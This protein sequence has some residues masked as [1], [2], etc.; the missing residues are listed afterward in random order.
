MVGQQLS[1]YTI[2]AKIGEG[3]MGAVY[4]AVDTR[5]NRVVAIKVL[6]AEA[7]ADESRKRRFVQE[8]QAASALN[9]PNIVTIYD[10]DSVGG[11]DFIAMEHVEGESLDRMIAAAPLAVDRALDYAVQIAAALSAAH[12]AG[13]IHRDLK[14]ANV[15]VS[16]AGT[17]KV[18]DFGL[19]KLAYA[20]SADLLG[21]TRTA[22]PPTASGLILGTAGYMAPEQAEG[23]AVDAR[24]DIFSF[25]AVLYEMLAGRRA[26]EGRSALS[27]IA[28]VLHEQPAPLRGLRAQVPPELERIVSRCLEKDPQNRYASAAAL[29]EDLRACQ[30]TLT[31]FTTAPPRRFTPVMAVVLV[32]VLAAAAAAVGW[33]WVRNARVRNARNVTLPQIEAMIRNGQYDPAFRLL[34]QLERIIPDDPQLARLRTDATSPAS[35]HTVPPGAEA[36]TKAYLDPAGEWLPLGRTPRENVRVPFGY[37]RWRFTKEGYEPREGA[38]SPLRVPVVTLSRTGDAPAGMVHVPGTYAGAPGAPVPLQDF[39]LDR[40]EVTNRQFKAFVDRGAYANRAYWKHP[41]VKDGRTLSWDEAMMEFRDATGRPGPS[42]WELGAYP[43][44]RADQPVT[45]VSWYEAAAYADHAG[46]SLPSFFHWRHAATFGIFSDILVLSNFSGKGLA[47]V[48]EYQGLATFGTFD[49]AGNAK[50]WCFNSIGAK[51]YILGGAW[52]EPSYMFRDRDAQLPFGREATYGF[53]CAK[54]LQPLAEQLVSPVE[55]TVRD[56]S[57]ERPASDEAFRLYQSL[58]TYDRTPLN[59]AVEALPD[60]SP[61]W[62]KEK[63]T[64]DAA[65]GGERVPAFL[66]LP[67]RAAPPFQTVVYFPP[68]SALYLRS[69]AHLETRQM[70]FLILSGRAVLF[71]IYRGTYDRGVPITGAR[72]WRDLVI[73]WSKDLGRSIDYLETRKDIVSSR[74]AFF[75]ISMGSSPTLL[76]HE[77][78]LKAAVLLGAGFPPSKDLPEIDAINFAPRT[79]VPVL[80]LNGRLDFELPV[81]TSQRPMFQFLGAPPQHK[82]HVIFE[83]GHAVVAI[84]PM[85]REVLDW[86][87]RYLGPVRTSAP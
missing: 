46:K 87:D 81:E 26:F 51:R 80:M 58:Y 85:I 55:T 4:R 57:K 19:A 9:H 13:I 56:Y 34:Q 61:H 16:R 35:I 42:T 30:R 38:S 8:A 29:Q 1:H 45:G 74:L 71:P 31:A 25:G 66:F 40:F 70:Q 11:I 68:G 7:T 21:A 84:Q 59:A 62:R 83:S 44:E 37:R 32:A 64:F 78:R 72:A 49:M 27:I 43:E 41:F 75:G 10:I 12:Q 86:L 22:T 17:V 39:W 24:T 48:G 77:R 23:Q 54:Y 52:N 33:L 67:R 36:H 69:T 65:Y 5:L 14:P 15:I 76:A 53:R 82:K 28:A 47:R 18:L 60:D 2:S 79:T 6:P 73:Q 50:E 63:V 20:Q 3:G